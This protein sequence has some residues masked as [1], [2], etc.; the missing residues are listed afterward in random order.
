MR[1][2]SWQRGLLAV[3]AA[4]VIVLLVLPIVIVIPMGFTEARTMSFPPR[5]FTL[6]WFDRVV[7]DP[8][9]LSRI[10]TSVQ[11]ALAASILATVLGTM[12]ALGLVRGRFRGRSV[13]FGIVLLPLIVPIVVVAIGMYFVWARGWAIGPVSVG[14]GLTG[15][16]LGLILAHTALAMP[17]PVIT[18]SASLVTVDRVLEEAGSSLGAPPATVFRRITLPLILPGVVAGLVFAFLA[19]WDEVVVAI[20]PLE[21]AVGH[22]ARRG[23]RIGAG[24]R[25]ADRRGR[26]DDP[27]GRRR[28]RPRDGRRGAVAP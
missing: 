11:V 5:G 13:A 21:P 19:S 15:T 14:G 9:W 3:V 4:V 28:G 17:F 6:D 20:V 2:R 16:H 12:L 27:P 7:T 22:G 23:V 1:S 10:A 26:F 8:R 18:V 25:R 24:C